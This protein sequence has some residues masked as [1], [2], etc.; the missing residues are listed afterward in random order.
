MMIQHDKLILSSYKCLEHHE[1]QSV[2][3]C[4]LSILCEGLP[5]FHQ[6]NSQFNNSPCLCVILCCLDIYC[7]VS[8]EKSFSKE[9]KSVWISSCVG[10]DKGTV[11]IK[12]FY[13]SR[14]ERKV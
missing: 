13:I 7:L 14:T 12:Q 9:I 3:I 1:N 6:N 2:P 4:Q 5:S 11:P 10:E 8:S